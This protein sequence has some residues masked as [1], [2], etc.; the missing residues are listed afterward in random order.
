M[1]YYEAMHKLTY[2]QLQ[3]NVQTICARNNLVS[4]NKTT[5]YVNSFLP[6]HVIRA[7][8]HTPIKARI[9]IYTRYHVIKNL[10]EQINSELSIIRENICLN[11]IQIEKKNEERLKLGKFK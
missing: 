6:S 9:H 8:T 3:I 11:S 7:H 10:T 2:R 4:N 1:R 5:C